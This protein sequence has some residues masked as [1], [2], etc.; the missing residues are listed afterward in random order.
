VTRAINI[1]GLD[2]IQEFEGCRLRAYP[3]PGTNGA[4]WTIGYGHT[5]PEV[6]PG[7]VIT[8][9]QAE[10]YLMDDLRRFEDGVARIAP[11]C[12]DNQ[13]AALVSFAY[14]LGLSSLAGSTLLKYHN[15]GQYDKANGEFCKWDH[16]NGRVSSG[17]ER[18]RGAE[19]MLYSKE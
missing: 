14:N 19:A 9:K 1:A 5:G 17:L 15:A 12:T 13:Y 7:M 4:P 3:D 16:M 11:K 8:D 2:L 18:R 10:D 6:H